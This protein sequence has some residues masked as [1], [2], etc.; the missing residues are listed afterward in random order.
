MTSDRSHRTSVL[1]PHDHPAFAGHF[2]GAPMLPG[3]VL[4]DFALAAARAAGDIASDA[5]D[6]AA[7]KFFRPVVPGTAL[8]IVH[9]ARDDGA[10]DFAI[11]AAGERVASG[12]FVG[13]G[14]TN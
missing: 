9:R 3:V 11:E 1:V 13:H 8:V 10:V 4:L 6:I 14:V 7:A 12:T 2:P 5:V